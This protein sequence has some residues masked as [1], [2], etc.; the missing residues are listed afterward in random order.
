MMHPNE[1]L[2]NKFYTAFQNKD[3]ATMAAS[4]APDATFS[5]PAFKDLKGSEP[6]AMWNMLLERSS[7]L[8]IRF[9]NIKA[10]DS[11]GSASWEADYNF[12]KT[13]RLVQNKISASF[14]FENGK[15]KT[16][17]DSFNLWKWLGMALGFKG[18]LTGWIPPIRN[19]VSTEAMTGLKLY[20]KRKRIT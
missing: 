11:K 1:E 20:M 6:G 16:H 18:Y 17:V 14:T 15:I 7:G 9:S 4:Y 3:G 12:S 8:T 10:D 2:I 13:G 19:K 5:D